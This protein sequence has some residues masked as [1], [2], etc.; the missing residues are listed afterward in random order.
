MR[1]LDGV[2]TTLDRRLATTAGKPLAVALS[3]GGDS[4]ALLILTLAWATPRGRPVHALVFDHGLQA[5]SARW[6]DFAVT[7]ATRLGASARALA[8]SG[9]KPKAGLPAAARRARHAALAQAARAAGADVLVMGHTADDRLEAARMRADGL[10]VSDPA[11]WSP[12]PAWPEGRGL[13]MLRP[14]L[15]VRR[16]ALRALLRERDETWIDDPANADDRSARARARRLTAAEPDPP[17]PAE[18]VTTDIAGWCEAF[19]ALQADG[20]V[21]ARALAAACVCASGGGDVPDRAALARLGALAATGEDFT[22]TLAGARAERRAGRLTISR[23]TGRRRP[24]ALTLAGG[25]AVW[26]G[27]FEIEAAAK[28]ETA[29]VVRRLGGVASRLPKPQRAALLRVPVAVRPVLPAVVRADGGVTCPILADGAWG[30]SATSLVM[31][32][33]AAACGQ[34]TAERP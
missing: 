5:D 13:M 25:V 17:P 30:V 8:W 16:A 10:R 2:S 11:I 28:A 1:G 33:F 19:G 14:L 27:R 23:E 34:V 31:A 15:D 22:A 18:P 21:D 6:T 20:P 3:G 29:A 12:S 4:L 7:T 9:D 26:D 32:R 24:A